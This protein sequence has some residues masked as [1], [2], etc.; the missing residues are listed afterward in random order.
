[1]LDPVTRRRFLII[2]IV[3]SGLVSEF[4]PFVLG[5]AKAFA[6]GGAQLDQGTRAAMVRMARLLYPHDAISD[7]VY[8]E[9][10]DKAL[11]AVATGPAFANAL[12]AAEQA[13]SAQASGNW[14]DLNEERQIAAM[15]AIEKTE[16]FVTIQMAVQTNLYNHP[17]S[18]DGADDLVGWSP[19]GSR[20][21]FFSYGDGNKWQIYVVNADGSGLTNLTN[22]PGDE[23]ALASALSPD[24]SR[25]AFSS[26]RDGN[27]EIYVMNA[28]GSVLTNLTNNPGNDG[29]L[30]HQ[31]L[32][33]LGW[34]PDGSRISFF[35]DRDGNAEIYV[36]NADGSG[37]TNLTNNSGEDYDPVWSP[38]R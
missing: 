38:A 29:A 15:K 19:D 18:P 23:D 6:Q 11:T 36:M 27:Y 17:G 10:L 12:R 13:L 5:I 20:I 7:A 22:S 37:Q 8:T 34:S 1:M 3:S 33:Y 21:T 16:V 30:G 2:A 25:I 26:A 24:G 28:D 9:V 4:G 14:T 35:S 32:G 31:G